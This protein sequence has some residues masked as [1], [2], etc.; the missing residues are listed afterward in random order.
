MGRVFEILKEKNPE[1]ARDRRK[2]V[3]QAPQVLKDGGKKTVLVNF[4]ELCKSMHRQPDHVMAFL[5]A[6]AGT[7]GS[8]DGQQRLVIK[9]KLQS[10][11]FEGLIRNYMG[12]CVFLF[13]S[14]FLFRLCNGQ[15]RTRKFRLEVM[16]KHKIKMQKCLMFKVE[17]ELKS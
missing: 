6:E 13:F 3:L 5:L 12:I 17:Y 11:N 14:F 16:M 15:G 10:K 4:I 9:S 2:A 1:L 7:T 8:L